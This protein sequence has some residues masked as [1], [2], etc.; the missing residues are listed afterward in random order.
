MNLPLKGAGR[1]VETHVRV[2]SQVLSLTTGAEGKDPIDLS[3]PN[4]YEISVSHRPERGELTGADSA[5]R[6]QSGIS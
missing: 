1:L 5:A 3:N 6:S 4:Y 2:S